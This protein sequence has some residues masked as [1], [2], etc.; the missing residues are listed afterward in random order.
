LVFTG[1]QNPNPNFTLIRVRH[2]GYDSW[3]NSLQLNVAR[4]YSQGLQMNGSYTFSKN[5]DTISGVQTAGDTNAGPNSIPLYGWSHLYKGPSAFDSRHVF[6]FNSTYELPIGPG[7]ALG[8]GLHG[9]GRQILAGWQLGGIVSLRSG[10]VQTINISNR[11]ANFGVQ[12]EF[13]DLAP[14]ASNNPVKGVSIGCAGVP[15]GTPVGNPNLWYDPCAFVLP[16]ANTLGNLG[17]NTVTMPGRA[18]ADAS[19]MKNFDVTE[20]SKLQFRFEAFN[21]FNRV[22]FGTPARTVRNTAGVLN[23]TAGRIDSTVG[24][25]RQLQ[26]ALKLTF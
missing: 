13:P 6:S 22:N 23:A 3:Y 17:R 16:P 11:L 9:I 15:A 7:K 8:S 14:G 1:Q 21:L 12:E 20:K 24:T 18:T 2:T 5:L 10:F 19:L 25:P 4:R 26:F